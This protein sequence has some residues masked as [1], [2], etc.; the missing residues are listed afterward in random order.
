MRLKRQNKFTI[1]L[2]QL[3][4][5]EALQSFSRRRKWHLKN[6]KTNQSP[7]G[8]AQLTKQKSRNGCRN[9]MLGSNWHR[10]LTIKRW[11]LSINTMPRIQFSKRNHMMLR[12]SIITNN[13]LQRK[14]RAISQLWKNISW[15]TSFSSIKRIMSIL[16]QT[17]RI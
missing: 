7:V 13:S 1:R 11:K 15:W 17:L 14:T 3:I 6:W 10:Q 4:I 16:N 2:R 9:W 5:K 12:P 8:L